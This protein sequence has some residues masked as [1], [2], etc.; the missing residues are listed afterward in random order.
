MPKQFP[1]KAEQVMSCVICAGETNSTVERERVP[2]LQNRA[3]SSA[4]DARAAKH[5]RLEVQVCRRCGHAFNAAFDSTLVA[6]D[7]YYNND[8]PSRT[9][10]QYY[11][12]IA[13]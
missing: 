3:Y 2:A 8:V 9:F 13:M 10:D 4:D 5:G 11:R 12:Q 7:E 6:Y 1:P